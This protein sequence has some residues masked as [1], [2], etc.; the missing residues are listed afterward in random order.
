[1]RF[2]QILLQA[3]G[4]SCAHA[5][6]MQA[7]PMQAVPMLAV[8]DIQPMFSLKAEAPRSQTCREK[9]TPASGKVKRR[10]LA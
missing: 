1:M 7:V 9:I 6:P 8:D 4:K 2:I 10:Q 5:V 3:C